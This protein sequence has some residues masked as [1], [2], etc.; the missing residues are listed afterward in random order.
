[1]SCQACSSY[2]I[3][4]VPIELSQVP[5]SLRTLVIRLALE[6][7]RKDNSK[8]RLELVRLLNLVVPMCLAVEQLTQWQWQRLVRSKANRVLQLLFRNKK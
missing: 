1:M 8:F 5:T 4:G 3:A 2:Q 7:H 6:Y